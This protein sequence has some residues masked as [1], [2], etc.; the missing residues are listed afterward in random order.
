MA[1]Y[2]PH[3]RR[4]S[5]FPS[6]LGFATVDL[7]SK[8]E[9][10]LELAFVHHSADPAV[11]SAVRR[12]TVRSLD[13]IVAVSV[14]SAVLTTTVNRTATLSIS[15]ATCRMAVCIV[16]RYCCRFVCGCAGRSLPSHQS[17]AAMPN[18]RHGLHSAM[19]CATHART[20]THTH[21]QS[22]MVQLALQ[23]SHNGTHHQHSR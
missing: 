16:L 11:A 1:A 19:Q 4:Q 13:E 18:E 23:S 10:L 2:R 22:G 15:A 12:P 7:R 21:P 5:V 14:A 6:P 8:E 20:H 9:I 17:S 3:R